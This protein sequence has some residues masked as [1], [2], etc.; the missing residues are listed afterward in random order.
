MKHK[1]LALF[2]TIATIALTAVPAFAAQ[3]L[4][5]QDAGN[6][7]NKVVGRTGVSTEDIPTFIGN[8]ITGILSFVGLIFLILMVYGGFLWI[9]ARGDDEQI[10]NARKTIIGAIIGMVILVAAYGITAFITSRVTGA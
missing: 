6:T 7:L 3:P 9:T 2:N 10:N 8:I 4:K 5:V 1:R